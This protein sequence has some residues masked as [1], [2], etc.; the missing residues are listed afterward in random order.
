MAVIADRCPE[1]QV[2]VVNLNA[3]R[4]AAWN[5]PD[6]A[7]L[8]VVEP[9]PDAVAARAAELNVWRVGAGARP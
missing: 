7:Q 6:L 4:I 5:D 2:S 1:L 8:P 9:G 3:E